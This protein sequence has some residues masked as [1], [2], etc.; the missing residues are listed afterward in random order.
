MEALLNKI[1]ATFE[2]RLSQFEKGV[3]EIRTTSNID[4][5]ESYYSFIPD[6]VL[7]MRRKG[8]EYDNFALLVSNVI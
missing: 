1:D 6:N 5:L 3:I 8:A 2:W 7:E 4:F